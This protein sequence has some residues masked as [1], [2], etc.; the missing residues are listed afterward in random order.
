M[1]EGRATSLYLQVA[2]T[3]QDRIAS[4]DYP[5]GSLLPTE[6]MLADQFSVSRQTVRQAIGHLRG[7]RLLS[8][9]K[10]VGTRVES[11]RA[12]R[13]Y[14]Q[15]LQSLPDLF[16]FAS[17]ALFR[18]TSTALVSV[19]GREADELGCRPGRS[20]LRLDGLREVPGVRGPLCR[21]IVM[22]DARYAAV[23]PTPRIHS[24]AIFAQIED[25]FGVPI[26]EV[27]QDIEATLLD[28]A[29]AELL[30]SAPGSAALNIT[31]RYFGPGHKLIELSR[32]LHPSDRFRYSMTVRRDG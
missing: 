20:W 22:I 17:D 31:R 6:H 18:V 8:A 13:G 10:G 7:M 14:H 16:Q 5:V 12:E 4:G 23:A 27:H 25:Q 15:A 3:L 30:Q 32:S 28:A 9:R 11:R 19:A 29:Q 26:Q 24:R 2:R 1:N 21:T